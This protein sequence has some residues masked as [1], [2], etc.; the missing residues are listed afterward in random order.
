MKTVKQILEH[1]TVIKTGILSEEKKSKKADETKIPTVIVL[2]RK[3][4]RVFPDDQKIAL[5]YSQALDKHVS[6]PFSPKNDA[7]GIHLSEEA[8]DEDKAYD[9]TDAALDAASFIPGPA[10]SAASLASAKRSASKGKYVDAALDVIGALPVVGYGGKAAKV[11]KV[12]TSKAG[13]A[14]KDYV[15]KKVSDIAKK[16]AEAAAKKA[17]EKKAKESVLAGS[18]EA[19]K[20]GVGKE[21]SKSRLKKWRRKRR[22]D[23]DGAKGAAAAGAAAGAGGGLISKGWEALKAATADRDPR[24]AFKSAERDYQ[25]GRELGRMGAPQQTTV[26]PSSAAQQRRAFGGAPQGYYRESTNLSKIKMIVENKTKKD[27]I[28][29]QDG[30]SVEITERVAKKIL[31]IYESLNKTNK[32]NLE[33][34]LNEDILSFRKVVNFA[35]R[36]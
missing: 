1:R 11:A 20:K 14:L 34:M 22:D 8:L 25:F 10:G 23:K 26:D 33:K 2:Q 13:S 21:A 31:G 4:I 27:E 7:L 17:A 32:K 29:F 30:K 24:G 5:Y 35:I 28:T 9:K 18:K 15:K 3:A 12:A 6:I 16:R 19:F 36:Q